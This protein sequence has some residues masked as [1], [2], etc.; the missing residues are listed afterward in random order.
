MKAS[1]ACVSLLA[2]NGQQDLSDRDAVSLAV[3]AV[4]HEESTE[5]ATHDLNVVRAKKRLLKCI[6]EMT[7][8]GH[9]D[10]KDFGLPVEERP[11]QRHRLKI[12]NVPW[13]E[14]P[15]GKESFVH[16]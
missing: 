4:T 6:Q 15:G 2:T 11:P 9:F 10:L 1:R 7:T 12:K 8:T 5:T 3:Q 14:S 16:N 13:G